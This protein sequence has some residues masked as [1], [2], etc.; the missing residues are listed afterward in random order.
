MNSSCVMVPLARF[1][2]S[3]NAC[4]FRMVWLPP[5]HIGLMWSSAAFDGFND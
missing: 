3:N 2:L 5:R 4:M 1:T